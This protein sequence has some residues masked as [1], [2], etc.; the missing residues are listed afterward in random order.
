MKQLLITI[1]AVVLTGC[2]T[3]PKPPTAK[4]SEI[5]VP[6]A[7]SMPLTEIELPTEMEKSALINKTITVFGIKVLALEGVT[8]RDLKLVANVLA[9]WIDNDENGTP[10]NPEVLAEIVRQKSRMI[11]GVTFDQ[12]GFWHEKSQKMLKHVHAPTY[13]LDVTTIN[14]N[15]YG[16]SLSE[17][18]QSHYLT[19][20]LLPPDAATEETFHLITD[21]GYANVYPSFFWHGEAG[22][23]P[24]AALRSH[25]AKRGKGQ[26]DAS[27]LTMAMDK[28]RGGYFKHMPKQ[29]PD[30]AWYTRSDDCGYKCFVGEYIH[31]GI[32]T[33]VGYNEKRKDGIHNQWQ[34][35]NARSLRN[36]DTALYELLTSPEYKF[37][38]T[39]PDGSY[40][41]LTQ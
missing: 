11:L 16:L 5:P 27:L 23:N 15:W 32:I 31:W 18:S 37:P 13:G 9:Q 30:D 19:E 10:D 12:I 3:E 41:D 39:A 2:C 26:K 38:K 28:A 29:Y 40:G 22:D 33:L 36:R 20:G 34:I 8:D 35:T 1:T 6:P 24:S 17:Y 14:H 4:A 7:A 25:I 21:I